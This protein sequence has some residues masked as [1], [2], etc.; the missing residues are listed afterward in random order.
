MPVTHTNRRG[1]TYYLHS[2]TTKAGKPRYW[3]SMKS[4]GPLVESIPED[5]EIY[6]NPEAQVFLRKVKPQIISPEEVAVVR[7]GLTQYAP[8]ENCLVDLRDAQIVIYHSERVR[9]GLEAV[10]G[11]R[12]MPAGLL[13]YTKVMRFILANEETRT[14]RVQRWCFRGSI[15]SWIDLWMSGSEGNLSDLIKTYCPHIGKES[16]FELM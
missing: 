5:H 8:D 13:Y 14:F 16:F 12:E 9:Y 15:D 6:E 4:D 10:F 3:F 2:G 11:I 7:N 1:Q